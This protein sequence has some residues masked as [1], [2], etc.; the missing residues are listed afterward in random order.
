MKMLLRVIR[1]RSGMEV[2]AV[3][4]LSFLQ[5]GLAPAI[6]AVET[7]T[8]HFCGNHLAAVGRLVKAPAFLAMHPY[9]GD[10]D[11]R[12]QAI[13]QANGRNQLGVRG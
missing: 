7:A 10:R 4:G 6:F 9:N 5:G 13:I 12:S 11:S 3:I 1:L 8:S 2:G